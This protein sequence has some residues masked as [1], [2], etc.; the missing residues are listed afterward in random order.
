VIKN[1]TKLDINVIYF[2]E[3]RKEMPFDLKVKEV[4]I[5][6]SLVDGNKTYIYLNKSKSSYIQFRT[7]SLSGKNRYAG[8]KQCDVF[9]GALFMSHTCVKSLILSKSPYSLKDFIKL[10]VT[11]DIKYKRSVLDNQSKQLEESLKDNR[12]QLF[13]VWNHIKISNGYLHIPLL[14]KHPNITLPLL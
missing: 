12:V 2:V 5:E 14:T 1:N 3:E 6:N 8:G 7:S 4:H 13:T 11:A 9:D 10:Q